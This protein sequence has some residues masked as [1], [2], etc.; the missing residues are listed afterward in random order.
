MDNASADSLV[1]FAAGAPIPPGVTPGY[2]RANRAGRGSPP[3]SFVPTKLRGIE[4]ALHVG[5]G[6]EAVGVADVVR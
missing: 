4:S 3:R 6:Q 2:V 1:A 5:L